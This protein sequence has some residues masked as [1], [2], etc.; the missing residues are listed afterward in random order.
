MKDRPNSTISKP[1]AKRA[2]SRI[3]PSELPNQVAEQIAKLASIPASTPECQYFCDSL[4][5]SVRR[6]WERDRRAGLS[7]PGEA[8]KR[9]AKAAR[10]L[11]EAVGSLKKADREWVEN[12]LKQDDAIWS[13][14]L[15]NRPPGRHS[16]VPGQEERLRDL[17]VKVWA[18]AGLFS[19]AAGQSAPIAAGIAKLPYK[20]G[21]RKGTVK[22]NTFHDLV[23]GLCS[24][25]AE[26]DGE[27]PLDKGKTFKEE[28]GALAEAL[29][30][31]RPYLPK[32]V[33]PDKLPLGTLQRIK[34]AQSKARRSLLDRP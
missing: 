15:V 27:L 7:E 19:T 22:D 16:L 3:L 9:A 14:E 2:G 23:F 33:I 26:W 24:N 18:L 11:N 13:E 17:S 28:G 34:T 25:A 5:D 29:D 31:L 12:L 10:T 21:K 1:P 32:G 20:V 30:I 4:C 6:I 8:L